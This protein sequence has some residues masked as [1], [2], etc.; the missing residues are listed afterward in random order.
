VSQLKGVKLELRELKPYFLL[1]GA[2]TSCSLLRSDLE[3]SVVEIKDLKQKLAHSSRYSVLSPPCDACDSLKGMF[4][5][6]TKESTE[7]K[8]EV[9]YL[10]ARLEK[11]VLR[12]KMIEEDLSQVKESATKST[13]KL[14]V[15][16]RGV[17]IRV[18]RVH[19]HLFLAPTTTRRKPS[20][21]PKLTT[22]PIQRHPL[23]P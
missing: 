16:L 5:H 22:H 19:P 18:R 23:T 10:T 21:P 17:R 1:L 6:V 12:K 20:N 15:F 3:T 8:Q 7:V 14:G 11:T 2:F 13:Y 4:F 9:A